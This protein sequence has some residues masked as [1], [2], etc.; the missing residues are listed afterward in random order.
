MFPE[1]KENIKRVDNFLEK[2]MQN[3]MKQEMVTTCLKE[4]YTLIMTSGKGGGLC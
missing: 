4:L 1:F 3:E 2:L